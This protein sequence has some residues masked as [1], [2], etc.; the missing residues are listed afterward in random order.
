MNIEEIEAQNKKKYNEEFAK[1]YRK[2]DEAK[3][4]NKDFNHYCSILKEM[5]SSFNHKITI[6]DLG[7]GTGTYFH[8]LENIEK[9]VAVDVSPSMLEMA[10][11]PVNAGEVKTQNIEYICSNF[12]KNAF[13]NE[14][15][16]FIY[17]VGVLGELSPLEI[18]F[19]NKIY[20]WLRP[21][22]KLYFT[23]MDI[24]NQPKES[25]YRRLLNYAYQKY[26][27]FIKRKKVVVIQK[28][29]KYP[30]SETELKRIFEKT[31]FKTY[32]ISFYQS[33]KNEWKGAH[34]EVFAEK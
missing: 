15:F 13:S 10:H 3:L 22:G 28:V 9:L 34:Y 6:L 17:S 21:G 2:N 14:S 20:N 18:D 27:R 24:K 16:D 30:L 7:C 33:P 11:N 31:N 5:S 23:V 25:L 8:C 32:S 12:F 29:K 4:K 26:M 19:L 1:E